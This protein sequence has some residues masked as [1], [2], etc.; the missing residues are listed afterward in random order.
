MNLRSGFIR[1]WVAFSAVWIA[2]VLSNETNIIDACWGW[3]F[4][5]EK[6]EEKN[7]LIMERYVNCV[8]TH[9]NIIIKW[10]LPDGTTSRIVERRHTNTDDL[11]IDII[12]PDDSQKTKEYGITSF[13]R[14]IKDIVGIG[15]ELK[16]RG[17][18]IRE[19]CDPP[20]FLPN[21]AVEDGISEM[22]KD[23]IA[24]PLVIFSVG[25]VVSW[26]WRGFRPPPP[27]G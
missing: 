22:I 15:E 10:Q 9:S 6:M 14:K 26:I 11:Y 13:S 8:D 16:D 27:V 3:T 19:F 4:Q 20:V 23:M 17:R 1:L 7:V 18:K 12:L 24:I 25:W 5:R 21:I 2:G